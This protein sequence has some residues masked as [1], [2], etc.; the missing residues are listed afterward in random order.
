MSLKIVLDNGG[1][2]GITD[3]TSN[4]F[5]A[6]GKTFLEAVNDFETLSRNTG[7]VQV[8]QD[9]ETVMN[10]DGVTMDGVQVM[11][12]QTGTFTAFYYYHGA[13]AATVTEEDE[14]AQVGRILMGVET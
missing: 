5:I 13:R 14:Y 12:N 7:A 6:E 8:K 4:S 2:I 3:Y 10:A 9:D 1:E 11:H